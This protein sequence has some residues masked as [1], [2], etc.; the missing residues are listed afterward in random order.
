VR[1]AALSARE[2]HATLD[3]VRS[4]QQLAEQECA[5]SATLLATGAITKSE[6][7]RETARC[8]TGLSQ[9][10][11]ADAR[12]TLVAKGIADG[13]VRAPFDGVIA[14][15]T[16]AV[17][18]WVAPGRPLFTIV[19]R[20]PLKVELAVPEAN[21]P[22]VH[23]GQPVE[24]QAVARPAHYAATVTHLGAEIDRS[25]ALI[26]EATVEPTPD[27][28]PGMFVSARVAIGQTPHP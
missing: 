4:E 11:A 5:R 26:V 25:R 10:A 18:E 3:A 16:V 14:S 20:G 28:L 27:L 17:G 1:T 6:S 7:D 21:V 15:R 8:R 2:A 23:L 22:A 9:V 12:A 13:I 19:D 24:L